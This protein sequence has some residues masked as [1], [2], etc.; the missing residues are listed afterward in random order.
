MG[1]SMPRLVLAGLSGD[2]G[3]TLVSL[4]ILSA[5]KRRGVRVGVFKKGP[6]YIDAAWL[7]HVSGSQCRNL[8]TYLVPPQK[9]LSRFV[10]HARLAAVSLIE[11]NRGV[12]DGKDLAGTHST[13]ELAK[14]LRSP[15]ILIVNTAKTTRTTAA[16]V[17]GCQTFDGQVDF[18]GVVL[19]RVA[20]ARHEG[21]V[22]RAIETYCGIP[23]LGA[24]PKLDERDALI[25]NRHLGLVPPTEREAVE[26]SAKAWA[27]LGTQY[28]DLEGL[29]DVAD[30]APALDVADDGTQ[31]S[32]RPESATVR[33]GYFDD[34]V[35]TFYYPENL[36]ALV[37]AGGELV[38]I[39]SLDT[40][41]LPDVDA[42]Y[43]GG[44]FPETHAADLA[45]N[46]SL[47]QSV[48]EAADRGLPIYA[49]CGGL[50]YLAHCVSWQGRSTPMSGVF[51]VR[52]HMHRKP[53]GHGYSA[54]RVDRVN[55]FFPV[56]TEIRGHEFHYSGSETPLQEETSCM[57]MDRGCGVG[58]QR[59]GLVFRN[60]L[61]CYSHIHADGIEGWAPSLISKALEFRGQKRLGGS[62]G[63]D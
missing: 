12:Y 50:I 19:N 32:D 38:S 52:L 23:V 33:I 11:G 45:A 4:S 1:D 43:I 61:A 27:D 56:G 2:S 31:P 60:T 48:K 13:A 18:A 30:Q 6:D 8:D 24:L 41:S 22:R 47:M 25:P 49:E 54:A 57:K 21:L 35:F 63:L 44:G 46:R 10:R 36:E 37:S 14:M 42:L 17:S 26:A 3:K 39:S 58:G 7:R 5:L 29:L 34:S 62:M 40:P 20:G 16:L 53:V 51:P 55:P 59:D 9:V 15:V 28:L